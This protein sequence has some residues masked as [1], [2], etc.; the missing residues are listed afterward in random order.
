MRVHCEFARN[1]YTD[2]EQDFHPGEC[3]ACSASLSLVIP[4]SVVFARYSYGDPWKAESRVLQNVST[5]ESTQTSCTGHEHSVLQSAPTPR[6][7]SMRT[8]RP[9]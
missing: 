1:S 8:V 5:F 2:L 3:R 7:R 6:S 4:I 9:R